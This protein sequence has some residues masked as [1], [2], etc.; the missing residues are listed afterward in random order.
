M[1]HQESGAFRHTPGTKVG[2]HSLSFVFGKNNFVDLEFVVKLWTD[3]SYY[4]CMSIGRSLQYDPDK[5][6]NTA[7]QLFWRKGYEL[8]SLQDLLR[9]T[10]LSKSSFYQ[11]FK[12]KSE[13]FKRSI[14][15]YKSQLTDNLQLQ[16]KQAGSG[17]AVNNKC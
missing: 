2:H 7:M 17:Q 1:I 10:R 15:S 11:A 3:K 9:A 14:Q 4:C 8:T 13:L 12:S 6:L 16:L 5:A